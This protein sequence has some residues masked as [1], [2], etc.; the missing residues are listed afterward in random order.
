LIKENAAKL[1]HGDWLLVYCIHVVLS[2]ELREDIGF[3]GRAENHLWWRSFELVTLVVVL[4]QILYLLERLNAVQA[5]H[6][7]V[8]QDMS[9]YFANF[10]VS[11]SSKHSFFTIVHEVTVV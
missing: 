4:N 8:H 11:L 3:V 5:G 10:Q 9:C 2:Q 7:K 1:V 6:H